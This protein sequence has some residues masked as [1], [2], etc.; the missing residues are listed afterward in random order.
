MKKIA[1]FISITLLIGFS[2][3]VR[4]QKPEKVEIYM[5]NGNIFKGK[6]VYTTNENQIRLITMDENNFLLQKSDIK[7][8]KKLKK[9][10]AERNKFYGNAQ[11]GL[12]FSFSDDIPGGNFYFSGGYRITPQLGLGLMAGINGLDGASYPLAAEIFYELKSNPFSKMSKFI[13][14]HGGP[15]YAK[16]TDENIIYDYSSSYIPQGESQTSGKYK[17]YWYQPE[18]GVRFN[19]KSN[20]SFYLSIGYLYQNMTK[21]FAQ[22]TYYY[23]K[24][25]Q[26]IYNRFTINF[27][28]FF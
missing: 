20:D 16:N 11:F 23:I 2:L 8:I 4:A 15:V 10:M 22:S 13:R 12:N 5:K 17:G 7:E 18:V 6:L 21:E 14:L 26:F 24:K 19:N 25:Q 1:V 9:E 28:Y 3:Q 27:G